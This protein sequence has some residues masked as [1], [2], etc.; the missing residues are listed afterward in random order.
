MNTKMLWVVA[1]LPLLFAVMKS[2]LPQGLWPII[3]LNK[4]EDGR[5]Y[6]LQFQ[7]YYIRSESWTK[8]CLKLYHFFVTEMKAN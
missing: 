3:N 6:M 8:K 7:N 1:G 5:F 4:L 2:S